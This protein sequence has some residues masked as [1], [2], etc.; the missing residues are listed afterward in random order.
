DESSYD[1]S[2]DAYYDDLVGENLDSFNTLSLRSRIYEVEFTVHSPQD[3]IKKQECPAPDCE[4]MIECHV[5]ETSLTTIVPTVECKCSNRFCFGCT[6]PDH[7]PTTCMLVQKWAE[8]C[9]NDSET[10][11]WISAFT[12]KCGRCN[13]NIEKKW[14]WQ[15]NNI[16]DAENQQAKSR[17]SLEKYLQDQFLI[18]AVNALVKCHMTLKWT[19]I[20]AFY[21][22]RN[23]QTEI[24]ELNQSDIENA[25]EKLSELLENS[26]RTGKLNELKEQI[27]GKT[28]YVEHRREILLKDTAKGL[29]EN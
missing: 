11:N 8:K 25:V 21:L 17:A 4:Y 3:I 18:N 12:K 24:F 28:T 27:I 15:P 9:E 7:Q 10:I 16:K 6:L 26:I 1:D 23:N 14:W 22:T 5:P 20:F 2:D 19:Y 29:L 13:S